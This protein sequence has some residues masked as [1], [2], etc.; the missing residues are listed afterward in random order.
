MLTD[1][2]IKQLTQTLLSLRK[3]LLWITSQD[4][5]DEKQKK[6]IE[7]GKIHLVK[8]NKMLGEFGIELPH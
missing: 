2:D 1:S 6:F 3:E 7:E 4:S 5:S 8:V